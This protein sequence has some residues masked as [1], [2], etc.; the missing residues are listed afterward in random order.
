VDSFQLS[1]RAFRD[2]VKSRKGR[3]EI[4]L[5]QLP[6]QTIALNDNSNTIAGDI[7]TSSTSDY[8]DP[9]D[10]KYKPSIKITAGKIYHFYYRVSTGEQF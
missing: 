1:A 7:V 2:A 10:I 9:L 8:S 5:C 3:I 4:Y 6:V